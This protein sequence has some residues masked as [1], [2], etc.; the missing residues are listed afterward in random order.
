MRFSAL[1]ILLFPIRKLQKHDLGDTET[2][3]TQRLDFG[4]LVITADDQRQTIFR[5]GFCV[6]LRKKLE[7]QNVCDLFSLLAT[8]QEVEW[9]DGGLSA[10]QV[11]VEALGN[12]DMGDCV[13]DQFFVLEEEG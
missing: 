2:N 6:M 11:I 1:F 10:F 5:K 12:A 3:L 8:L 13:M 4:K 9:I 7:E